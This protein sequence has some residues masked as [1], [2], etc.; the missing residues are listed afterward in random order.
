MD[1]DDLLPR[2]TDD[3]LA[4]LVKQDLGPLS[5]DELDARIAT[6]QAEIERTRSQLAA[7]GSVKSAADALFAKR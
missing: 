5:R 2:K 7:A 1:L 6:L 4:A 3:P